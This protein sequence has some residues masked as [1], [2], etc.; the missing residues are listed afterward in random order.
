M[1]VIEY[2]SCLESS[3]VDPYAGSFKH[4]IDII[5]SKFLSILNVDIRPLKKKKENAKMYQKNA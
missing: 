4:R 3:S 2:F 5:G 1:L